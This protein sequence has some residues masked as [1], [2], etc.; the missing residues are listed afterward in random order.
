M[1]ILVLTL[2]SCGDKSKKDETSKENTQETT[3]VKKEEV[4]I[5]TATTVFTSAKVRPGNMAITSDGKIFTTMNPL[6]SPDIKVHLVNPEDNTSVPYPND[7]YAKGANSI[8]KGVIGI[9]ADKDDNLWMLDMVAKKYFGWNTKTNKLI[10]T[11]DLPTNVLKPASFLQDFIIDEK[12]NRLIIADM[13]QGDLKSAPE[14]AFIVT[15]IATGESQRM[16]QNHPSMM[17]EMEGGFAL[18]P[19]GIDPD[20]EYVYFGA[21]HGRTL[22]RVPAASFDDNEKLITSIKKW[23]KKSYCD[24]IAV[25]GNENV[26]VTNIEESALGVSNKNGFKNIAKLPDGQSWPD[27][28]YVFKGDVYSTVDQLNRTAALNKGND[29]SK[30]PYLIIK[31]PLVK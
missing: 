3:D 12:R 27:G 9:R 13:T 15:D 19:I 31:T 29:V 7:E 11:I 20:F 24:G 5:P 22:Y 30:A 26:Y 4:K 23:G 6:V 8:M 14:P 25:D 10:K 2:T 21:L 1:F 18:N 17:P 16:A 28:P